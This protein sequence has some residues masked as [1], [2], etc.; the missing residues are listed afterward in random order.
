MNA[1]PLN[2][3]PH[4]LNSH[5]PNLTTGGDRSVELSDRIEKCDPELDHAEEY[6]QFLGLRVRVRAIDAGQSGL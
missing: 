3:A 1:L 4:R 2:L 5:F 6:T